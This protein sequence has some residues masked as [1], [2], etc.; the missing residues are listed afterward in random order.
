MRGIS[1]PAKLI[2]IEGLDGS[3]KETQTK[4]L[5]D[6]LEGMGCKVGSVSFPQ[7][8]KPSAALVEDYLHGG[9]GEH[10]SDVN[11]Y[12]ASSFFAMD[13]LV[14]YLKQWR[15]DYESCD[16]FLADRY[17]TSNAI[18]Q[19]SKLPKEEWE[20]FCDWLYGYEFDLLGLPRPDTVVYLR[21]NVEM[22]QKL[23]KKRYGGDAS[24]RDVHER[25]LD[26]LKRSQ[27]AAEWCCG[28]LGW[29]PVECARNGELRERMEMSAE[30]LISLGFATAQMASNA[31]EERV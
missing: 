11:A 2:A 3:G 31:T 5:R 19:C 17:T 28:H 8:G 4:L 1:M 24:K 23:L 6:A 21:M 25:D 12:A 29:L 9:F 7:Y 20:A 22:S 27:E 18:H 30:I 15:H 10:A 13:R 14:S 26:Y 16:I